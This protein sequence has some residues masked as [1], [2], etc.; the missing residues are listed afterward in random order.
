MAGQAIF[1]ALRA[2][3]RVATGAAGG[4]AA[5]VAITEEGDL[6]RA[7]TQRGGTRTLFIE[8][9]IT[10]A[11]L[12]PRIAAARLAGL[13]SSRPDRPCHWRSSCLRIWTQACSPASPA[14]PR[15]PARRAAQPRGPGPDAARPV[16]E[17]GG[18]CGARG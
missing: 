1:D 7:E 4:F 12:P 2:V 17:R 8:G 16:S 18:R 15:R 3:E 10:G 14:E 5:F 9:E 13:M 6:L 11:A